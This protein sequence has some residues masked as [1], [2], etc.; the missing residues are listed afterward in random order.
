MNKIYTRDDQNKCRII[1][2][3]IRI[4]IYKVFLVSQIIKG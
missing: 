4:Y 2:Q 1:N 3:I